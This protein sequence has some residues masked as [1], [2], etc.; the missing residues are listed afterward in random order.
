MRLRHIVSTRMGLGM[1]RPSFF[2]RH[3]ALMAETLVPSLAAQTCQDFEWILATDAKIDDENWEELGRV[4]RPYPNFRAVKLDPFMH[5]LSPRLAAIL[6]EGVGDV[7]LVAV[8]R[9]DDDDA[10]AKDFVETVRREALAPDGGYPLAI[11]FANGVQVDPSTGRFAPYTAEFIA[12]GLTLVSR[13]DSPMDIFGLNHKRLGAHV[14]AAGGEVRV[15][16]E[17]GARWIYARSPASDSGEAL[18]VG[19]PNGESR[20]RMP[21][22]IFD[23]SDEAAVGRVLRPALERCGLSMDWLET[24]RALRAG[25]PDHGPDIAWDPPMKRMLIKGALLRSRRLWIE[26]G[27]P[28]EPLDCAFYMI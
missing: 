8:S 15:V 23:L 3:I 24:I 28:T 7:D 13:A 19:G 10:L 17:G 20:V 1:R 26:K 11:A 22:P 4:L 25:L 27:W 5:G 2:R 14:S 21:R 9:V 12:I 18:R 16:A 6:P